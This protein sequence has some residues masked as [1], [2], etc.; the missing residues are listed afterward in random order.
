M[1]DQK[2]RSPARIWWGAKRWKYNKGLIIAGFIAFI[3]YS[4]LGPIFIAP[5]EEFEET[6]FTIAFQGIF[7]LI[8]IGVA[9]VFYNLG[10][11][12]DVNF[13]KT[14]SERFRVRLFALGYWFSFA[15]PNLLILSVM[16]QFA[17]WGY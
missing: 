11:L 13:N 10:W 17:I 4:I 7:Y 15:L 16:M 1:N 8:M 14:N 2:S 5:H 6:L 9:N 3:L 12:L